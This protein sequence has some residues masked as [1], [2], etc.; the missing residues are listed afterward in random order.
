MQEIRVI[1]VIE[2]KSDDGFFMRIRRAD[3]TAQEWRKWYETE[4]N[5]Y[6]EAVQLGLATEEVIEVQRFSVTV[7]KTLKEVASIDAELLERFAFMF[8]SH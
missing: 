3:N 7:R 2:A 4:Q 6:L 1:P 5:A 8:M